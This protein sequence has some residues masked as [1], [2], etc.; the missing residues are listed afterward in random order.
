MVYEL[1]DQ[2]FAEGDKY[3]FIYLFVA[4]II[5]KE[6]VNIIYFC[7]ILKFKVI[8]EKSSPEEF[9]ELISYLNRNFRNEMFETEDN[10]T[11]IFKL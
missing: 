7:V 9:G 6:D 10:I 11:N 2:F 3:F 1:L 8:K 5:M 4:T